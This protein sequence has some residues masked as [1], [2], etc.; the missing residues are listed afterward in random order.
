M[1]TIS[2]Q[3][4]AGTLGRVIWAML[5]N[6]A[7]TIAMQPTRKIQVMTVSGWYLFSKSFE[8]AM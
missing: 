7:G 6:P 8:T 1:Y 2:I 5:S 4:F 3:T